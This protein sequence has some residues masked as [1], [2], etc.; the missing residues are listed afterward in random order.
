MGGMRERGEH[1]WRR[2][3]GYG[4]CTNGYS[5]CKGEQTGEKRVGAGGFGEGWIVER[6]SEAAFERGIVEDE[7]MGGE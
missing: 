1:L 2:D 3:E 7:G 4:S 6:H 5:G